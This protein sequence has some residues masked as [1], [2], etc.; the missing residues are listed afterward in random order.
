[1][2]TNSNIAVVHAN[3]T[4]SEIYCHYDGYIQHNGRILNDHYTTL[5]LAEALVAGGRLSVLGER[6][7]PI[8]EHSFDD[9]EKGTCIYYGRD[10]GEDDTDPDVTA[11]LN[12]F[13]KLRYREEYCYLFV[14]GVWKLEVR[15]GKCGYQWD[16]LSDHLDEIIVA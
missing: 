1:M 14:D 5:E 4:V 7:S 13:H 8:G 15:S 9:P 12:E 6:Q 11:D 3:G 16:N 10:R 2:S